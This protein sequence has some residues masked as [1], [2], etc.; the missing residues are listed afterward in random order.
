M[1]ETIP[2]A[3]CFH[4]F[5]LRKRTVRDLNVMA[6]RTGFSCRDLSPAAS[7]LALANINQIVDCMIDAYARAVVLAGLKQFT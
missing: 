7:Q 1:T 6:G 4:V 3:H 2:K 5:G